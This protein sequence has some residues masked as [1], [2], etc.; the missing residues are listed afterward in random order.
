M[1][2]GGV[3]LAGGKSARMGHTKA[4]IEIDGRAMADRVLDALREV[5]AEPLLIVGGDSGELDALTAPV[6]P[7]IEPGE[8]PVGGVL[9]AL[10][11]AEH[12]S[13][14]DAIFVLA[15][16]LPWLT[17]TTLSLVLDAVSDRPDADVWVGRASR[18]EPMC[19]C[20]STSPGTLERVRTA[21]A[22]G[23]RAMH[24]LI[25]QLHSA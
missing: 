21:Y 3:V 1:R 18:L 8:G 23:E 19:A 9:S 12:W 24:R 2:I 20:W 13:D 22:G 10:V 5:G 11:H 17:A 7:D 25:E 15:C 16:D 6:I 14:I 4:L